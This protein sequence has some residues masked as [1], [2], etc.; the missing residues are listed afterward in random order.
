VKSIVLPHLEKKAEEEIAKNEALRQKNPEARISKDYQN[1]LKTW[2]LLH[3]GRLEMLTEINR[4]SRYFVCSEVTKRPI[5]DFV[6]PTIRPD[7]TLIVFAF[8]DD[9]SF[10]ILQSNI[11]W[12]WFTEKCSTL[13]ERYRYTPN[14][15]YDTFPW[16]Q[17]PAPDQVKAVADAARTLHEF[18]RKRMNN[19]ETIT[20]RD[21][22][23][24][25]ELPGK[26]PLRD[27]HDALDEAV[28]AA[29]GFD[30]NGDVLA[31]LLALNE[32]VAARINTGEAV[33]SPGVPLDYPDPAELISEGCIQPPELI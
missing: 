2:W 23:R 11:H 28:L 1:A 12:Q 20:L 19:S 32:I 14:T 22:Y 15:V 13:T 27:L 31:Q 25:L 29:Y 6:S 33:T 4:L 3:R 9:Y 18:R 8:E 7:H 24:T 10:G 16:P 21:M 26:N 17:N 5:F 30:P